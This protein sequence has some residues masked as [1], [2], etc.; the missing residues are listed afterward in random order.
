MNITKE[1]LDE[2]GAKF[3]EF[4]NGIIDEWHERELKIQMEVRLYGNY[5]YY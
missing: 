5:H 2:I 1:N 4:M 3:P